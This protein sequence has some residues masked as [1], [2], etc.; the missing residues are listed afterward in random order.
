MTEPCD[1]G[2]DVC[3]T[4]VGGRTLAILRELGEWAA[5]GFYEGLGRPWPRAY[6]LAYRRMYENLP[7]RVPPAGLLVPFEPMA[8]SWTRTGQDVWSATSLICDHHHHCGLRV[9]GNIAE[10]RKRQFPQHARFIDRLCADLGARLQHYGGYTHSNPDIRRVVNEGFVAIEAELA[11]Q[12]ERTRTEGADADP[13]ALN[14][15]LALTDYAAGVH[16]FYDRSV[17]ALRLAAAETGPGQRHDRLQLMADSLAAGFMRPAPSFLAGLLAVNFTWMLDGCDSIG[18]LDQTLGDLFERDRADGVLDLALARDLLDELWQAFERLNGWNLQIGGFRPDGRDGTNALT[19]ECLA[20]CGRN[21]VRRPNV[22]FRITRDTPDSAV[23]AALRVLRD[24]SGRPALYN[25]DAYV[26]ALLNLPLGLTPED[27]REIGFGGCTETMI[28][29]LSNVGSL[30]GSLNLAKALELALHDG[31]DP[32]EKRQAG[33][34]T[35]RFAAFATCAEFLAAV[36]RQIQA[37]TDGYVAIM[38]RELQKRFRAGDPKLARTLFTRDCVRRRRSF[39]AG[40]ARYNWSVVS[41]Q[42]I[43]NLVDSLAAIRTCVYEERSVR[44][45]ELLSALAAD[46]AGHEPLRQRLLAAPKFGND[47][48]RV[49]EPGREIIEFAWRELARHEPPRGGRYLASC[50]LFTTYGWEGK[51]VGAL[52]DGRR[53]QEPLTDSVGAVQGRDTHG[54]TALL[55][56]VARLPLALAP[57]TPVLNIRFVRHVLESER[58]LQSLCQLIRGFFAKGGLQIQL[59]VIDREAMLAAQ[60]EPERH[61]DLIVRIGGYS[62]YFV[63]LPKELQDSV[64]ARTEHGA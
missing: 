5:L 31:F 16:V 55:N 34:H 40:G 32:V 35:G 45:D 61:R 18:R 26:Q 20:A 58:G 39:E 43:A 22:A 64:I 52:P 53:A 38:N 62:E 63:V 14:L 24:G 57:G 56:S 19:L 21:H 13:A 51:R 23:V 3:G 30:E 7:V 50:I 48:P 60:R 25:D 54:P 6:G 37:M 36:R 27:A 11:A 17:A 42:G 44:P 33:P 15:L 28:A 59:S 41:Y 4:E 10:D 9:N 8:D 12:L 46:F 1:S 47:D 49:D 29:G 2:F